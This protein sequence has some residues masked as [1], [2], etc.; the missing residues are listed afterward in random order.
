MDPIIDYRAP[1]AQASASVTIS[2]YMSRVFSWMTFGLLITAVVAYVIGSD[3]ALMRTL[4]SGGAL[5]L[6]VLV[7]IRPRAPRCPFG[8]SRMSVR[9][10]HVLLSTLRL[11][12]G[13]HDFD[14]FRGLSD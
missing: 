3:V 2:R 11:Q 14:Y 1:K 13:H 4:L 12:H 6:V 7:P 9:N 10:A 8:M 5:G